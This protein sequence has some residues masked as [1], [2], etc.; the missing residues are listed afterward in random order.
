LLNVT[1][2]GYVMPVSMNYNIRIIISGSILLNLNLYSVRASA[3]KG[4]PIGKNSIAKNS[5]IFS[6]RNAKN[7]VLKLPYSY[8]EKS[9]KS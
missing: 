8:R 5:N 4:G 6:E 7:F 3:L 2:V 1:G 9:L